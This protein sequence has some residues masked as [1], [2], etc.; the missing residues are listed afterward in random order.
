MPNWYRCPF[1]KTLIEDGIDSLVD[2][3]KSGGVCESKQIE[4]GRE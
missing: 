4:L 1:C 3:R 2:H